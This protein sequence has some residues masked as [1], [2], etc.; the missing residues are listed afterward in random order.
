[1]FRFIKIIFFSALFLFI[2]ATLTA[3]FLGIVPT[4]MGLHSKIY[5][6]SSV[7]MGGYDVVAYQFLKSTNKG[8]VR[9]N[10]KY[11][12]NNWFFISQQHVKAFKAKHNK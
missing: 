11:E 8:D 2:A 9:F 4:S 5:K 1:M 12:D 6:S 7:A 10:Y 3:Y